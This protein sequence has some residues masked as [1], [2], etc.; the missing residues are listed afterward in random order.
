MAATLDGKI[1]AVKGWKEL[2]KMEKN[3]GCP[4]PGIR[5]VQN[6]NISYMLRANLKAPGKLGIRRVI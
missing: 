3:R 5:T 2:M 1:M 4:P 6:G